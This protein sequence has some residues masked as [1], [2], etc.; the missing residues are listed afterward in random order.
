MSLEMVWVCTRI[1]GLG[2]AYWFSGDWR[3][4]ARFQGIGGYVLGFRTVMN[5]PTRLAV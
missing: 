4:C 2:G 3:L 1:R 5:C